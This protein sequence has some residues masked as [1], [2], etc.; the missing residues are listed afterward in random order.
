MEIMLF[1]QNTD[2][3]VLSRVFPEDV[4]RHSTEYIG[5][6]DDGGEL[7]GVASLGY[8]QDTIILQYLFVPVKYRGNGVGTALLDDISD[9]LSGGTDSS[10][11]RKEL[12]SRLG[13]PEH[14]SSNAMLQALNLLYT[15]DE[16]AAL[17]GSILE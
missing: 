17:M 1:N 12:L 11:K 10:R 6:L 15:K 9:R 16:L 13:L 8:E 7:V 3:A 5:A 14:M 2:R 4:L